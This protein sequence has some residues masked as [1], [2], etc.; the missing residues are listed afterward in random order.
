MFDYISE[1]I[2]QDETDEF[3]ADFFNRTFV[4]PT[5]CV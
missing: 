5:G 2:T 4:R 1:A 3:T